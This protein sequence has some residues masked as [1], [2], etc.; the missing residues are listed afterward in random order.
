VSDI[1]LTAQVACSLNPSDAPSTQ[2]VSPV[3][4]EAAALNRKAEYEELQRQLNRVQHDLEQSKLSLLKTKTQKAEKK[5]QKE[6][7]PSF[8]KGMNNL[9]KLPRNE[10]SVA[11][12][13]INPLIGSELVIIEGTLYPLCMMI[14]LWNWITSLHPPMNLAERVSIE[15]NSAASTPDYESPLKWFKSAIFFD[16]F[17]DFAAKK[18][19]LS[20]TFSNKIDPMIPFC[21]DEFEFGCTDKKCKFQHLSQVQLSND[22]LLE[23]LIQRLLELTPKGMFA[24]KADVLGFIH[25]KLSEKDLKGVPVVT[26]ITRLLELKKDITDEPVFVKA[27]GSYEVTSDIVDRKAGKTVI[28]NFIST[29]SALPGRC[30]LKL[31]KDYMRGEAPAYRRYYCFDD[32]DE[33]ATELE[34]FLK[35]SEYYSKFDND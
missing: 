7:E 3:E 22:A 10:S 29:A 34:L 24:S 20:S 17:L 8:L 21:K 16:H 2:A 28:K 32:E 12:K 23:S 25:E 13:S 31:T 35:V 5:R 27:L 14:D 9:L 6:K 19:L 1:S 11:V 18:G 4:S 30:Y 15:L 26:L 33:L